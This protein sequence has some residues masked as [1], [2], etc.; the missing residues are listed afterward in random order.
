VSFSRSVILVLHLLWASSPDAVLWSLPTYVVKQAG[1]LWGLP[2][3]WSNRLES[4][5]ACLHF[6]SNRL[7]TLCRN[8]D[9][10]SEQRIMP[11]IPELLLHIC[12]DAYAR[13][14]AMLG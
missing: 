6:W 9:A 4:Y 2:T 13:E 10:S 8:P 3:L 11:M 12:K 14:N 7:V 5:G 1:V